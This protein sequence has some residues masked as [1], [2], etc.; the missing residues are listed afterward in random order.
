MNEDVLNIAVEGFTLKG[1]SNERD[2]N[3]YGSVL[4]QADPSSTVFSLCF[5]FY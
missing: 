1:S 3:L 4:E 5:Y 2:D